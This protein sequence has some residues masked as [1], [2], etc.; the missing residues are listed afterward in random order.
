[1]FTSSLTCTTVLSVHIVLVHYS[2]ILYLQYR[3]VVEDTYMTLIIIITTF[4]DPTFIL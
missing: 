1:M 3:V 4:Y 2:Y